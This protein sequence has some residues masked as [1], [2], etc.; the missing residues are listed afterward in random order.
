MKTNDWVVCFLFYKTEIVDVLI[1]KED[2][3]LWDSGSWYVNVLP[4]G[5]RRV[6][7]R[8]GG[9]RTYFHKEVVD[10]SIVDHKNGN[11]LDNRKYNLRQATK[12]MNAQNTTARS[13]NT[14]GTTGV[15]R[16]RDKWRARINI[17]GTEISLG[18]FDLKMDA[19]SARLKAEEKYHPYRRR[20]E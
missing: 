7:G 1:D 3:P 2:L 8:I 6:A 19:V 9:R 5:V 13:D 14:S 10:Y 18:S 15:G 16:K 20:A 11:G 12:S 4:S 17:D